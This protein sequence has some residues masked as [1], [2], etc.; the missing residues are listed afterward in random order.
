MGNYSNSV[1]AVSQATVA[2]YM[3]RDRKLR[4]QTW[5]TFL[6]NHVKQLVPTDFFV[7]ATVTFRVLT[8]NSSLHRD[9]SQIEGCFPPAA[10]NSLFPQSWR[11]SSIVPGSFLHVE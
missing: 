5:R 10:G 4:S 1:F 2:K 8:S 3:A 9:V 7:V 11:N 6:S